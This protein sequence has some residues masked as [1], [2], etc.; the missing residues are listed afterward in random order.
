MKLKKPSFDWLCKCALVEKPLL[1]QLCDCGH[2]C[3]CSC[4]WISGSTIP[5]CQYAL[6]CA[7]ECS[8]SIS[9]FSYSFRQRSSLQCGR[10]CPHLRQ[11]GGAFQQSQ[12]PPS[13]STSKF[14]FFWFHLS[15]YV[16]SVQVSNCKLLFETLSMKSGLG[17]AWH[18]FFV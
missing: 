10:S 8:C 5:E 14:N 3:G 13:S 6:A 15:L 2:G 12:V 18:F 16:H 1:F 11:Q 9:S 17:L 4:I 7:I